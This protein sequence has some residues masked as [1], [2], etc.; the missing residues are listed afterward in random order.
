MIGAVELAIRTGAHADVSAWIAWIRKAGTTAHAHPAQRVQRHMQYE[1]YI[2]NEVVPLVRTEE[3]EP[4]AGSDG[5]QLRRIL[6]AMN[7]ALKQPWI[8]SDCVSMSGAF[9]IHQ[10]I[11]QLLRRQ[12]LFQLSAR[13]Y[14]RGWRTITCWNATGNNSRI[15]LAT[16]EWDPCLDE[17]WRMARVLEQQEYSSLDGRVGSGSET[18]LAVLARDGSE[19]F[20]LVDCRLRRRCEKSE[21]STAWKA[22]SRPHW[23]TG[24]TNGAYRRCE[25]R[26]TFE[27]GAVKMAEPSGL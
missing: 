6:F 10:F 24:S 13:L 3:P 26:N 11:G 22:R 19:V 21:L 12:L 15:V 20:R 23:W 7:F 16:S 1:S 27:I 2:L 25:W 9:D 17:N 5:L 4:A 8:F 14:Y 18:R